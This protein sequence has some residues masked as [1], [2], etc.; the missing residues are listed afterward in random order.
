VTGRGVSD[1]VFS[2]PRWLREVGRTSWYLVGFLLV[3]GGLMWLLGATST[4]VVPV[5]A[6]MIVAVVTLPIVDRLSEHM[7][8]AAAAALVLVVLVV[9][10]VLIL[11]CVLRG[12]EDQRDSIANIASEAVAK[13][14]GW[15]EDAG[16]G[17]QTAANA[18]A[19]AKSGTATT[20]STLVHG[21]IEGIRGL[22]SL[23][24]GVS[25]AALSL[26]FILKDGPVM[27]RWIE[28][29]SGLPVPVANTITTGLA[30]SLRGYF[31]GVTIVAAFNAVIVTLGAV[32]LGVPLPGTIA[33]V[34]FVTA[35]VPYIGALLAGAFAVVLALGANGTTTA[36]IMLVIVLLANGLLQ[37]IVQPFAMGSSLDLN[38]L[39]VLVATIGAGCLFGTVGLILAA[40]LLSA[41]VHIPGDLRRLTAPPP[42]SLVEEPL[43]A[44]GGERLDGQ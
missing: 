10:A 31:R 5:L 28:R 3:V 21:V 8:R 25:F 34:T 29:H 13:M 23:A 15:L 40:P 9:V 42:T 18:D 4:I 38:P 20:V 27:H 14:Q 19:S 33:L 17:S 6:G 39:V 11:V 1:E 2:A 41:A 26:F 35:Y 7:P 24:F 22:A 44:V 16:V 43:A 12:I 36:I 37:N 30:R 32:V